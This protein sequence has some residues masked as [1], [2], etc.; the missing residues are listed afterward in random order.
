MTCNSS[1]ST[2]GTLSYELPIVAIYTGKDALGGMERT[3]VVSVRRTE[4]F[5]GKGESDEDGGEK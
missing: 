2:T 5:S 1:S 3:L 4:E